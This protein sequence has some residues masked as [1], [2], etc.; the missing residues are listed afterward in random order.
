MTTAV[1]CIVILCGGYDIDE[2]WV[3]EHH[4]EDR[5]CV[6]QCQRFLQMRAPCTFSN[7]T[8]NFVEELCASRRD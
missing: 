1:D 6:A 2:D 3:M 4:L 5:V 8:K 7:P